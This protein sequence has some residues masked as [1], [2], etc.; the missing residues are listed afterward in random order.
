VLHATAN[1]A[2]GIGFLGAGTITHVSEGEREK[3]R[4]R[5]SRECV[6]VY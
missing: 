5:V 1:I 3:E 4:E 6:S 2:T